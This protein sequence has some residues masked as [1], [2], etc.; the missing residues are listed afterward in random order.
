M[1]HCCPAHKVA[2]RTQHELFASFFPWRSQ[3]NCTFTRPYLSVKISCPDGPT[4]MAVCV[5]ST[6]AFGVTRG[7]ENGSASGM[8]WKSFSY[9][10]LGSSAVVYVPSMLAECST[11]VKT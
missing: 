3:K 10:K 4:T 6:R 8:H 5:P 1:P 9:F 7:G 2:T 11:R